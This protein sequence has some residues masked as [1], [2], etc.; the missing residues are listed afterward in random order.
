MNYTV[1]VKRSSE[2]QEKVTLCLFFSD[3]EC[4]CISFS[5]EGDAVRLLAHVTFSERVSA[6]TEL[7]DMVSAF[8]RDLRIDPS[9]C[10]AV[11]AVVVNNRFALI[12]ES[13][14]DT[15]AT[16]L[17]NFVNG[18]Q[19]DET[20][21]KYRLPNGTV[22]VYTMPAVMEQ[23]LERIFHNVK[24]FHAGITTI[25]FRPRVATPEV[26]VMAVVHRNYLEMAIHKQQQLFFYNC[27]SYETMDDILYYM[28]YVSEQYQ[29][30]PALNT[31]YLAVNESTD[32]GL[33]KLLKKYIRHL[34]FITT[35]KQLFKSE[36]E[37]FP[38]HYFFTL[39]SLKECAL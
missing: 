13:F 7:A 2:T 32:S 12:P 28:L 17:Y 37:Q 4:S 36:T 35:E 3:R 16:E 18:S 29:V 15:P 20:L 1:H 34:Q 19:K 26:F 24:F 21:L 10:Q 39:T 9:V 8:L 38:G 30:D 27:F 14:E 6:P 31:F 22:F 25:Q 33:S 5:A 23:A 11:Y